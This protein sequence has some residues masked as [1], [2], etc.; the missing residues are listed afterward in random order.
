MEFAIRG[1]DGTGS[2]RKTDVQ[3]TP[4]RLCAVQDLVG[5]TIGRPICLGPHFAVSVVRDH[6]VKRTCNARP[7]GYA[8]YTTL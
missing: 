6:C 8:R 7:Y 1:V 3:C 5:A 2:L 4:L